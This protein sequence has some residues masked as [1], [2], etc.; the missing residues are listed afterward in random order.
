M[1]YAGLRSVV[2]ADDQDLG[3]NVHNGDPYSFAPSVW[4]YLIERFCTKSVLDVGCGQGHAAFFF[5]QAGCIS[6][7]I[8]GLRENLHKSVYPIGLVDFRESK[9]ITNVDL[10]HSVELVEHIDE[11]FLPNL[12]DT[13]CCGKILV[14]TH[15]VPG[16]GGHHHVNC[17]QS[18]YWISRISQRGFALMAT[19][20]ARLRK[21][22]ERD[23]ADHFQKTG[24]VFGRL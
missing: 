12:L 6:Y 17:Q 4:T 5:H 2:S 24:L 7:A 19:D 16:Q 10:V 1:S 23:E 21:L 14:M 20:T 9:F 15:A 18:E 8:D 13:L 3:G 11:K 22:A